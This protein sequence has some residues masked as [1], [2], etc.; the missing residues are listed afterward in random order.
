MDFEE[1]YKTY[2]Q[3]VYLFV[4]SLTPDRNLA[5]EVT[6]E[7]FLKAMQN[8]EKFDGQKDILAW[9]FTIA[10]NT[11]FS[12]CRKQKFLVEN[13]APERCEDT[14]LERMIDRE[15][16]D[17]IY[18]VL[19]QMK[20][21][22]KEVFTLRVLGELSFERIGKIFGKSDGWARVTYYRAKRMITEHME[23]SK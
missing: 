8:I 1:T 13:E 4:C 11:Y 20:E 14:V 23:E 10:R 19:H 9:L 6:Q 16:A 21:P 18:A 5:E 3:N 12:H 15:Q 7:T 17:A 2:F 22:Y